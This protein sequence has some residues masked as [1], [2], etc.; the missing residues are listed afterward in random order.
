MDDQMIDSLRQAL[1]FS[2]DNVPLKLHLAQVLHQAN[3][4]EEAEKEY[5][6][7]LRLTKDDKPKIGLAVSFLHRALI[8]SVM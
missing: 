6:E 5:T 7:L 3:R 1:E 8:L 4:L 2:P